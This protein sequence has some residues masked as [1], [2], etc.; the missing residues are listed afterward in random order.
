MQA[1]NIPDCSSGRTDD[2]AH[3][4]LRPGEE[5]VEARFGVAEASVITK[6]RGKLVMLFP[7]RIDGLTARTAIAAR[8]DKFVT[9][10]EA[11][12]QILREPNTIS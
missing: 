7:I 10:A 8:S 9:F 3:K 6:I 12:D 1:A 4:Q 2:R 11:L 5:S